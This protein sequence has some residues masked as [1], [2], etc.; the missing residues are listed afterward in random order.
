MQQAYIRTLSDAFG[1]ITV[2][3]TVPGV[4]DDPRQTKDDGI[5]TTHAA[6]RASRLGGLARAMEA[7]RFFSDAI[8]RD[9]RLSIV[10]C[11]NTFTLY[12]LV[13]W[14]LRR[15]YK[16][17]TFAIA[18]TRPYEYESQ[19]GPAARLNTWVSRTLLKDLSGV[20][21]MTEPL[22]M[23]VSAQAPHLIVRGAVDPSTV[24]PP[25]PVRRHRPLRLT[26]AGTLY[27][28][29]QIT[30]L[31]QMME[32][33]DPGSVELHFYGRGP[34]AE[35]VAA[36]AASRTDVAFH[37]AV[38]ATEI[39]AALA[40]TD[41]ILVLLDPHDQLAEFS[42]PSKLFE[43]L[44]SGRPVIVSDLATL[45]PA[46][47]DFLFIADELT[48]EGLAEEVRRLNSLSDDEWQ[49]RAEAG[50]AYLTQKGTW[51]AIGRQLAAFLSETASRSRGGR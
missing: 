45:D 26:Y 32:L 31:L 7:Y 51:P 50:L 16:V 18:I 28:R 11:Y 27:D 10:V 48:P 35:S 21:A 17:A 2:F 43:A 20:I 24:S 34:L 9:P 1:P 8:R 12:A 39:R 49:T 37:G 13:L 41:L 15:R 30:P 25:A 6:A 22:A 42:F 3:S 33:V 38:P 19:P 4:G 29:Y 23:L 14:M 5:M 46:M 36:A 40:D 47:R 44:A